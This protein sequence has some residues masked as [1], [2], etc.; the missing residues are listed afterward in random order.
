VADPVAAGE[1][2]AVRTPPRAVDVAG[3]ERELAE[4]WRG[5]RG[6]AASEPGVTQACMSN[7]LIYVPDQAEATAVAQEVVP[8]A[9]R[10]PSRILLLVGEAAAGG[11]ELEAHVSAVCHR[12]DAGQQICSEHVTLSAAPSAVM[13]L[14]S[15]ARSLLI[16]DLPTA[17]WWAAASPPLAS[18]DHFRELAGM[19]EQVIFDSSIWP[20]AVGGMQSTARWVAGLG[21]RTGV[22]DLSWTRLV[23]WRSL[24]GQ[25]LDPRILPEALPTL[26]SVSLEIGLGAL[27]QAML[28]VGWLGARLGWR[29]GAGRSTAGEEVSWTMEGGARPVA[30]NLRRLDAGGDEIARVRFHW[31]SG[32]PEESLQVA[33]I[34]P[35]RLGIVREGAEPERALATPPC[36]RARLVARELPDLGRDPLYRQSLEVAR[37]LAE[38]GVR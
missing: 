31:G 7:L 30:V 1:A 14:P 27:A 16:G 22:S 13:R 35:S 21:P 24:I 15:V 25:A 12:G 20:D 17:L 18:G 33:R 2:S 11:G 32:R 38:S 19:A 28:L 8:I 29:L 34:S 26:R 4:L 3:I 6:D 10:H 36:E 23:S 37:A 9:E 5:A